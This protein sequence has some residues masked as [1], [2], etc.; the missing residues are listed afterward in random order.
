M[1]QRILCG[2]DGTREGLEA[3]RQAR[4]L[5]AP[6]GELVLVGVFDPGTAVHAGWAASDILEQLREEEVNALAVARRVAAG[7]LTEALLVE[8]VPWSSIIETA[9]AY[10]VDLVAVGTHERSRT[11]GIVTGSVTTYVLHEAPCSVLVARQTELLEEFP[12]SIVA[13]FDGS[14]GAREALSVARDLAEESAAELM[15]VAS[16]GEHELALDPIREHAPDAVIDHRPPVE[17]LVAA[18]ED[19]DLLVVGS[20]G[21]LGFAALG[22]VSER[23]AHQARSSVLVLRSEGTSDRPLDREGAAARLRSSP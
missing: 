14:D 6:A 17:A 21:L 13:G 15:V 3:V 23:V 11:S 22:S 7:S 12:R 4:R 18:S 5:L 16:A 20:R 1:F 10:D 9:R 2:V 19:A 8:G